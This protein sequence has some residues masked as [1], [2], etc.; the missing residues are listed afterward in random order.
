MRFL[1]TWQRVKTTSAAL[2]LVFLFAGCGG[3]S[4][5][6]RQFLSIGTAGTGGIYYPLG[7]AIASRLSIADPNR[8]YTAEVTGG[9]VENMNR[10]ANGAMDIGFS[11]ATTV[12]EA[13]HGGAGF[14]DPLSGLRIVAP[15]YANVVHVVVPDNSNDTSVGDFRGKR[16]S[17]GAPGSGT[18][19]LAR[20]LLLA[21]DI[22]YEDANI[23]YLSFRESVNALRD[24][25]I[26]GAII[27][28]GYPASSVLE[29]TTTGVA[30]LLP[31]DSTHIAIMSE[32]YPY[33]AAGTIPQGT[34]PRMES[35]VATVA[36]MNWLVARE[37]LDSTVVTNLLDVLRDDREDLIRVNAMAEQINLEVLAD[38]PIPLHSAALAWSEGS[39]EQR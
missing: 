28:V 5:G 31:V 39:T 18:E 36:V 8:Q 29:V 17:V 24:G 13:F 9:S 7:G 21:Y 26:D 12:Y 35:D 25:A 6:G 1:A 20:Q 38:S 22:T 16:V 14:D 37:D 2:A 27:C 11:M 33:Y 10:I 19:Q 32:T 4:G 3:G 30:Q 15:L 23:R 34:Y